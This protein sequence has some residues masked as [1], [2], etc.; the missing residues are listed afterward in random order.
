MDEGWQMKIVKIVTHH[1]NAWER[2]VKS[3]RVLT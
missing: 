2:A 1:G 3:K